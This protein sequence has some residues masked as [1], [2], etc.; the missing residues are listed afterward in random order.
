MFS[1]FIL[2]NENRIPLLFLYAFYLMFLGAV[3]NLIWAFAGSLLKKLYADHY[4]LM[5]T[6]MAL[7]LLWCALRIIG[8]L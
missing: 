7:L 6:V 3:G 1:S 2:P 4:R 8:V 5:N